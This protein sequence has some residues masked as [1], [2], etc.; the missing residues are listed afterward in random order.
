M[1][2]QLQKLCASTGIPSALVFF[3]G[4]LVMTF[5]PPLSPAL[6]ADTIAAIY[7]DNTTAIRAGAILII[8][9]SMLAITFYASISIQLRAMEGA[10]RPI[11]SYAQMIAGAANIQ[12]FILPGLL[13]VVASFR[14]Q[15]SPEML[16]TLNDLAFLITILPW[17]ITCIQ[18]TI[19]G[20]AI[21]AHADRN[22][23]FPRWVGFFNLWVAFLFLPGALIP[24]FKTGPFAWDGLLA[25]WVPATMF[26]LWFIVMQLHVRRAIEREAQSECAQNAVASGIA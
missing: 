4:M 9:S 23:V 21:L 14:P 5:L 16:Q 12:F 25:F 6:D 15:R 26:G 18:A 10:Q 13:F 2:T 19:C 20:V 1:N 17:P 11:M 22:P 7:R 24:F 8:I 3:A